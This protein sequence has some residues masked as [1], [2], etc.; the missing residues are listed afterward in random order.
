MAR[1]DQRIPRQTEKLIFQEA[2]SHCSFCEEDSIPLLDIHHIVPRANG[3]SNDPANLI[4][5]CKN[6][7]A[8]MESGTITLEEIIR[9]KQSFRI[10]PISSRRR[11]GSANFVTIRGD[12]TSSIIA[13]NVTIGRDAKLPRGMSHP[14]GSIGATLDKRNYVQYLIRRYHEF[15]RADLSYGRDTRYSHAVI[16]KNVESRFK[17]KTFFIPESRFGEL[18]TYL[19]GRIAGTIQGKGN[20][21]R[22]QKLYSNFQDFVRESHGKG[23]SEAS[24]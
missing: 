12:I 2:D 6:C 1:N 23:S 7:H 3:G 20:L 10:I 4:L 17:A 19:Q 21:S 8:R 9:R 13:N 22:G 11:E 16:H 18:V 24:L 14:L 5:A 15:R